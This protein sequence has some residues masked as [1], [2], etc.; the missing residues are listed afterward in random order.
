MSQPVRQPSYE[1]QPDLT[2][3]KAIVLAGGLSQRAAR[4]KITIKRADSESFEKADA[5]DSVYA[6]DVINVPPSFF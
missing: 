1:F 5:D 4:G 3:E 2:L 6:G